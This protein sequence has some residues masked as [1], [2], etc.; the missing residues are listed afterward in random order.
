MIRELVSVATLRTA[1]DDRVDHRWPWILVVLDESANVDPALASQ[2]LE[3]CPQAGI[4]VVAA[5][6]SDARVPRQAKATLGCVPQ[7]GG[8]LA[9]S[10]VWFTDPDVP[11]EHFEP[12]PA[13]ARLIDQ[14]A[15]SLAPLRDATAASATTAIPR[16]VPLLSLFGPELADARCRSPASGRSRS[17]TGCVLRSASARPARSSSTS[18]STDRTR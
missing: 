9:L 5:V 16:I 15:M 7:I 2:L 13:N 4:S 18:S 1:T 6:E 8:T 3:L 12:E 10:S 14:V 11:P 17:P